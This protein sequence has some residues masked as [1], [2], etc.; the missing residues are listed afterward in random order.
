MHKSTCHYTFREI[1]DEKTLLEAFRMRYATY[2]TNPALRNLVQENNTGVEMDGYD[3][4]SLHYGIF[5]KSTWRQAE[6]LVGYIRVIWHREA[7]E[8]KTLVQQVCELLGQDLPEKPDRLYAA[9][10][11]SQNQMEK[12]PL[13]DP[14]QSICEPSRLILLPAYRTAGLAQFAL[15]CAMSVI[16]ARSEMAV[17]VIYCRRYHRVFYQRNGFD[18]LA[19]EE[20]SDLPTNPW[21]LMTISAA[22]VAKQ[23]PDLPARIAHWRLKGCYAHTSGSKDWKALPYFP[24]LLRNWARKVSQIKNLRQ[25][26]IYLLGGYII[27]LAAKPVLILHYKILLLMTACTVMMVWANPPIKLKEMPAAQSADRGTAELIFLLGYVAAVAPVLEWAYFKNDQGWTPWTTVGL[28]L[29]V[30]GLWFRIWSLKVL[31][32]YFTGKV[33][34]VQGHQLVTRG[35]YKV[36]RH[37]SYLGS[38]V[39]ISGCAV[40]VEAWVGCAVATW[41][42]AVAYRLRINTEENLLLS[43]FGDDYRA[44]QKHSWRMLPGIW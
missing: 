5:A 19:E 11:F 43:V 2:I 22:G 42:M 15:E 6:K 4:Y 10:K 31:G 16:C 14:N 13:D 38:M 1:T 26:I 39:A 34:Q 24:E 23:L 44:Y 27:P 8:R 18:W 41:C 40:L 37:P 35:P 25:V 3:A 9:S 21:N 20:S 7:P 30:G 32:R 29:I 28:L 36:I 12:I 17:G 33:Q